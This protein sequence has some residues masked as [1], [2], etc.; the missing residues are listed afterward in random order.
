[1]KRLAI[2]LMMLLGGFAGTA[3]AQNAAPSLAGIWQQ[4]EKAQK[5]NGKTRIVHLPVWKVMEEGGKFS[6]FLIPNRKGATIITTEGT[7][8]ITSDSTFTENIANSITSPELIGK[9]NPMKYRFIADDYIE[10]RYTLP[11]AKAEAVEV[12]RRVQLEWP[13]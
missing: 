9:G 8:T 4:T 6:T 3:V 13:R 11:G 2:F 12:W 1:M 5:E 7:Y 10:V